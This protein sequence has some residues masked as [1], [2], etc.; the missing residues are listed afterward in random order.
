MFSNIIKKSNLSADKQAVRE[1]N[2]A[3]AEWEASNSY[4][5]PNDVEDV[6]QLLANRGYNTTNW[7]CLTEG[8][9]VYWYKEDN[10]MVLYNSSTNE[11]EYPENYPANLFTDIRATADAADG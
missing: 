6:M 7:T 2:E 9:E 11:I 4:K 8:Y 1:M 5:K 10:R 3:L